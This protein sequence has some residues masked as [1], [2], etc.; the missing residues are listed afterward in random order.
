MTHTPL[1]FSGVFIGGGWGVG[2]RFVSFANSFPVIKSQQHMLT[3]Q[4]HTD[5]VVDKLFTKLL[6]VITLLNHASMICK[7]LALILVLV[8]CCS[9]QRSP[10]TLQ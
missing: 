7:K 1:D 6:P 8:Q 3:I 4:H 10:Q 5:M 2:E 9:A